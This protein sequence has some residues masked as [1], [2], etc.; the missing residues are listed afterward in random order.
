MRALIERVYLVRTL[1]L[2]R[3]VSSCSIYG[4]CSL[5]VYI[6]FWLPY[7]YM[8]LYCALSNIATSSLYFFKKTS[9]LEPKR[10]LRLKIQ[11]FSALT[12]KFLFVY[13]LK[14]T[15]KLSLCTSAHHHCFLAKISSVTTKKL[16][17]HI[18]LQSICFAIKNGSLNI[19][20]PSIKRPKSTQKCIYQYLINTLLPSQRNL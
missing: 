12:T 3:K 8:Y 20:F 18:Q 11:K 15:T 13:T 4:V 16:P 19:Y 5:C 1:K 9:L 17:I 10:K 2:T 7:M 6:A 14:I